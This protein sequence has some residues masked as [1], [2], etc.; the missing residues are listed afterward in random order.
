MIYTFNKCFS[1]ALS[2]LSGCLIYG[3]TFNI[4]GHVGGVL[5]CKKAVNRQI[6]TELPRSAGWV[7]PTGGTFNLLCVQEG[8]RHSQI[9][10][11]GT[12][13]K[14][15]RELLTKLQDK[16]RPNGHKISYTV[17]M[18]TTTD[19]LATDQARS[20]SVTTKYKDIPL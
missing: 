16:P 13:Y 14:L 11:F 9:L 12:G 5:G 15:T 2:I 3:S 19:L 18:V 8:T 10:P 17:H 4:V 1:C 6:L 20:P 7:A